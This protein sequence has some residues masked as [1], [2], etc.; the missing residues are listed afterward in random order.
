MADTARD[1]RQ[2]KVLHW[3]VC[4]FGP[5]HAYSRPQRATRFLEEAIELFQSCQG[6]P[7][8]AHRLIDYIFAKQA[9]IPA[10][11]IGDVGLTLLSVACL[12]DVSADQAEARKVTET[13]AKDPAEMAARNREK[14]EAGF[15][16]G[17][18]PYSVQPFNERSR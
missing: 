14:N 7:A 1:E 11:E 18:Y 8:M 5:D 6:D 4:A 3:V 13:L 9:G 2:A 12:F 17:A 15:D 10:D 16:A